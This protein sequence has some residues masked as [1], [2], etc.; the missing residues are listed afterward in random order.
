LAEEFAATALEVRVQS[1]TAE[2]ERTIIA[3]RKKD[4]ADEV[5]RDLVHAALVFP[6]MTREQFGTFVDRIGEYQ[7]ARLRSAY[8]SAS[9]E[10]PQPSAD[11]LPRASTLDEG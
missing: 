9:T 2:E 10:E 6:K 8:Q 4:Q 7:W 5:N 11:F 1:G 3:G